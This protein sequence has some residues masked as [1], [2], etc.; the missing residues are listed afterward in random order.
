MWPVN[1]LEV[2]LTTAQVL[3]KD[4]ESVLKKQDPASPKNL[5]TGALQTGSRQ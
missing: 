2:L 3:L 1:E 4:L 5:R